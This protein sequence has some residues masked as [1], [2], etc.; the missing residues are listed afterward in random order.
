MINKDV[1]WKRHFGTKS[2]LAVTKMSI[3]T[4]ILCIK[5]VGLFHVY[6]PFLV[7]FI[8][9]CHFHFAGKCVMSVFL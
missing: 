2:K 4:H 5:I 6:L 1:G 7:I 9:K 3:S 8:T